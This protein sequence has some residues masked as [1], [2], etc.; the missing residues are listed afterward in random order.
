MEKV[1]PT[2]DR[3]PEVG[4]F[5]PAAPEPDRSRQDIEAPPARRAVA[6]RMPLFRR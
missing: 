6:P 5:Q 4:S 1:Q 2:I 3:Q